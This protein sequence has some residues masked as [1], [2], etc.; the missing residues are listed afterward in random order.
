MDTQTAPSA[1]SPARLPKTARI[2]LRVIGLIILVIMAIPIISA[3]S[4]IGAATDKNAYGMVVFATI[5]LAP[6][7]AISLVGPF[8]LIPLFIIIKAGTFG[9][10]KRLARQDKSMLIACCLIAAIGII[11][12]P[13]IAGTL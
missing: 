9:Q 13:A 7:I 12:L 8:A 1:P 2:L 6:V 10:W 3:L 5:I 11:R 4:H